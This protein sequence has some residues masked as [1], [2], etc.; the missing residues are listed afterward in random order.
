MIF[1]VPTISPATTGL[2][3]GSVATVMASSTALMRSIASRST[4]RMPGRVGKEIGAAGEG[5]ARPRLRARERCRERCAASFSP[6][7]SASSRAATR[8]RCRRRRG[9]RHLRRDDAA[10]LHHDVA[11][12]H[13]MR[14]DGADR[15]GDRDRAELHAA[16]P[17]GRVRSVATISAEDRDG[18]LRRRDRADVEADRRMDARELGLGE[19]GRASG[20][21]RA[22]H[23]S[24]ASR[25]RRYRS[26]PPAAPPSSA[27]SSIFGSWVSA[28]KR[29]VAVEAELAAAPRR[30]IRRRPHVGKALGRRKGGARIDRSSCRGRGAAPSARAPG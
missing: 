19:A 11:R 20:A 28:T 7:S 24:S 29:R 22:A 15:L 16:A 30:A 10:L 13:R 5:R 26:T 14:G 27:G 6:T 3:A 23:A 1:T 8:R 18:D 9:A 17:R 21:R 2:K 12:P 4:T 25:A